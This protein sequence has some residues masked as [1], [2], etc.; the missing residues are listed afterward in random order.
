MDNDIVF[1]SARLT[2]RSPYSGAAALYTA[3]FGPVRGPARLLIDLQ[4]WGRHAVAPWVLFHAAYPVGVGGFRI[5]FGGEGLE[6]AFDFLPE[7]T[8]Q[9]LASEFVQAAL[10]HA[11]F[12]FQEDSFFALVPTGQAAPMRILQKAG[13]T[14]D[15]MTNGAHL[16]RLTLRLG[17]AVGRRRQAV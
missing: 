16:M 11:R 2:G 1:R 15:R 4:D 3:L 14:E 6:L 9:G 12:E 13:F 10:D 5:G 17:P 7:V 8:G